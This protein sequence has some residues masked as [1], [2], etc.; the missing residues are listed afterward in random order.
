MEENKKKKTII[1]SVI[2]IVTLL[3]A[4]VGITYAYFSADTTENEA[5]VN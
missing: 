1:F 5:E 2:A 4:V 3:V